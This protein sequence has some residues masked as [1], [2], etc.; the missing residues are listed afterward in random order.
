MSTP[1]LHLICNSHIDPVW[2]WEWEEGAAAAISTFRTAADLCEQFD[3]FIFNHNEAILY[4]W[5]EEYA[6][7]LFK[8]IQKL[9]LQEKWHIMGGWFLQPDC[10]MPSGESFTRQI[11]IGKKYFQDKFG[12]HPETAINFDPFGHTRG[13][14]QILAKSG[15]DSYLFCR[16][17][18]EDYTLPAEEFVWEGFDGSHI[19]CARATS[20]YNSQLGQARQKIEKCMEQN[21]DQVPGLVLW[22]V[23]NHGG[24]PSKMD[25]Q[26]ISRLMEEEENVRII[27]STPEDYFRD[28]ALQQKVLPKHKVDLN[29]WAV[30]CYTSMVHI[31]QQHRRLENEY[32]MTEKMAA[33]AALAH[34]MDYPRI[35]LQ[36]ALTDL[37]TSEFHDILPGSS[38]QPVEKTSLRL[39]DHGLEILSR[40]K[41]RAFFALTAGQPAAK[42]GEIPVLVYNPHPFAV[43]GIF[44][45]EF[46]LALENREGSFTDVYVHQNEKHLPSQV[47]KE[48]SNLN[49]DWRKRVVFYATLQPSQ[50]NRFDCQLEKKPQKP[51]VELNETDNQ[52]LFETDAFKIVINS[53]TGFVDKYEIDGVDFLQENS[54][55]PLVMQDN[56]D[57]W[58]EDVKSFRRKAGA[59]ALM[60]EE[61]AARFSGISSASLKP[62]RIVEDGDARSVVEVNF[63]YEQSFI[64][65]QYK[66]PK[67]GT[68]I[69]IETRVLWNE[70]DKMLKLSVPTRFPDGNVLGQVAYGFNRLPDNG[71]EAVSQKWIAIVSQAQDFAATCINEGI[72]G[73]DY[74]NG[75][76]RFSLLRSPAYAALPIADRELVPQ[77][78]FTPRMNQGEH[79]YRLWF[80]AG[81]FKE[82]ME[83]VDR[84]ALV[85]N[86]KPFALSF[87]PHGSG[88][89][90]KPGAV[91][92]D[93]VV[94]ITA[95][96]WAEDNDDLIIRLFEPTG[97]KRKIQLSIPMVSFSQEIT[98]NPFEI[99]TLR[100][101][102][103]SC[104]MVFVDL[105]ENEQPAGESS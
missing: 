18:P 75:E 30:G 70:K 32:F 44:E 33:A 24:G 22:G 95:I 7:D 68:E 62:V 45:C 6:P 34:L 8:R 43:T 49:M 42:E 26:D 61:E 1:N 48:L 54:F 47:E 87:F 16:P 25:L 31:K 77:D 21:P 12:V 38:I 71:D 56:E 37:L 102:P 93:S 90:P 73:S 86:E 36:S 10:N 76:L 63:K 17:G 79:I 105:L 55:R 46:Q 39:M 67:H 66:L 99:K 82:R 100:I 74:Q 80:N 96:K 58:G 41:A 59:F 88:K 9:V 85:K 27:H 104:E 64:C 13:L 69:E 19:T 5:V 2:L 83:S 101:N 20:H 78:R 52:V 81:Q 23:G 60:T 35:E 51:P 92:S 14:V 91:L 53:K 94:Q 97:Q 29:P 3:T 57:S 4:K 50:M 15:Y 84:E 40:I 98:L 72:Y 103:Q 89:M 11:L 65:Q 28:L